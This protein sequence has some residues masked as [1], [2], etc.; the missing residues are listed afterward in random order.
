MIQEV[1]TL[2]I[3]F[4][5]II[6]TLYETIKLF[7]PSKKLYGCEKCNGCHL[8]EKIRKKSKIY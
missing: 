5:C 6:Y 4:I 1:I 3:V 8:N 2:L 7:I